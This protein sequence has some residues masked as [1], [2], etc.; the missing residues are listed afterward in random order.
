MSMSKSH[1]TQR[2]V[3][4]VTCLIASL[5][6]GFGYSWS[7]LLKPIAEQFG[8]TASAVSL[9][10]TVL[11]VFAAST[12]I[13]VGKALQYLQPR[14]CLLAGAVVFGAGIACLGFINSLGMLYGLSCISGIGLGIIYPGATMTNLI[15]YFPDRRGLASGL[16]A[17]GYGLGPVVWA[18]VTVGLIGEVG[19]MWALR[20]MGGLFFVLVALCS[21]LVS[22]APSG[23]APAGWVPK[24]D[25]ASRVNVAEDRD[26]KRMLK[27]PVFWVLAIL[28][29]IGTTSGL[30]VIGHAS[31]IAQDVLAM[32]PAAAGRVV[33]FLA[34]GMVLGKIG[35]GALSDRIGRFP[36]FVMMLIVAA[37]SLLVLW[38]GTSYAAV[39]LG[40]CAVG[41]CYGGFLSLMAP[42]T[43]EV[44]G[45]KNLGINFGIM[46]LTVALAAYVGPRLAASV[47]ASTGDYDWAFII[48]AIMSAAGLVLVSAY[49]VLARRKRPATEMRP[50]LGARVD[51]IETSEA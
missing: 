9:S 16:L 39:V 1:D 41:L 37:A 43:A 21:R 44:F 2:W 18:P 6:A 31:P 42:I 51:E 25:Q 13:F 40:I 49:M 50:R 30:M 29:T 38:H 14:T 35:W 24:A 46:F 34:V 48:A 26:W 10:F 36:V 47:H 15:R 12:S 22:T 11:I 3:T 23:Y 20:I 33:S 32:T 8:W 7:V 27:T 5:C 17:A 19:L 45:N 4:L 28:F